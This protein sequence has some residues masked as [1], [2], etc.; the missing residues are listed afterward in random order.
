MKYNF[1]KIIIINNSELFTMK[2]VVVMVEFGHSR[3]N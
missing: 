2:K 3:A 1:N